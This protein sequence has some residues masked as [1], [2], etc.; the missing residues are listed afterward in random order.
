MT[1]YFDK[2]NSDIRRRDINLQKAE[3][4]KIVPEHFLDQYPKLIEMFNAYYDYLDQ[5][6]APGRRINEMYRNRDISQVDTDLLQYIEDELLLGQAYFGGFINKREASKFSNTLYRSK[7]TRYSVQQFFRA[8]FGVDPDVVYPKENIFKIGPSIDYDKDVTNYAGE[9]IV[10]PASVIGAQSQRFLTDDKLYQVLA[11]LIKIDIPINIWREI[12]KLFVHPAGMYLGGQ[13]VI[14]TTNSNTVSNTMPEIA[15]TL[16]T[17]VVTTGIADGNVGL[18]NVSDV[19]GLYDSDGVQYRTKLSITNNTIGEFT[20]SDLDRRYPN[21]RR[22]L[23]PSGPFFDDDSA[24][25]SS[26]LFSDSS[27]FGSFDQSWADSSGT[28]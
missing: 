7:G 24:D 4:E 5:P 10:E 14:S 18:L 26:M 27:E 23:S 15:K 19:T 21:I 17:A 6:D 1:F 28:F 25:G 16:S 13:L 8:F 12:Y 9:Q 2:T 22:L 3:I 20:I 11:I